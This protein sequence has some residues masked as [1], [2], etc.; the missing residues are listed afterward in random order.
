M[1]FIIAI[2]SNEDVT[3]VTKKL[4]VNRFYVTKLSTTGQFLKDGNTT[5]LIGVEDEKVDEVIADINS[6]ISKRTVT[7]GGVVSSIEG[8]LLKKPIEVTK[9][10]ATIF[11]LD[12]D[13]FEKL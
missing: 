9:G 8:S 3:N 1:K 2:V 7:S 5:L 6:C 13:R 10:G 12:V 4:V 11:V